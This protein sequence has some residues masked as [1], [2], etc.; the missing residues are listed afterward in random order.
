VGRDPERPPTAGLASE[1]PA[2][3][4]VVVPRERFAITRRALETLYR[5][6]ETP[7]R[8]V[9]VDGGSPPD[10]AAYLAEQAR[11]RGFDLI[12]SERYLVPN[13]AR[14]M[15]AAFASGRYLVFADND[16]LVSRGWLAALVAC[17]EETGADLVGP[18]YGIGEPEKGWV[19]MAGGTARIEERE[20]HRV[21]VER[22]RFAGRQ[23]EEIRSQ[24]RREP[25]ELL[26]FHCLLVRQETFRRLGPLDENFRST[27]EQIDLCL[28]VRER[29]G[30]IYFEPAA[31]VTYLPPPPVDPPDRAYFHLRWSEGWTRSSLERLRKKWRLAH[32]DP[33]FHEHLR[34]L[35]SHRR[36]AL[37]G[38]QRALDRALG[39]R[40]A[41]I[42]RMLLAAAEVGWNRWSVREAAA[43]RMGS[44]GGSLP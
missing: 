27:G 20:G 18:L 17:A 11:E 39:K 42:P 15:G 9:Y 24:L 6:T 3:T 38:A 25:T 12:R 2:V 7:F 32:D 1:S 36:L 23:F 21:L 4:I 44:S 19:H 31:R 14:N 37:Q 22:H 5:E 29:G 28:A 16:L 30:R 34:W 33:Y 10:V 41:R 8:L 26:E 40:F 13:R 43:T 35:R